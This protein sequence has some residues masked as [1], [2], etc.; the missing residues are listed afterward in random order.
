MQSDQDDVSLKYYSIISMFS[1][2]LQKYY[3][4]VYVDIL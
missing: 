2:L 1:Y 4:K 3:K